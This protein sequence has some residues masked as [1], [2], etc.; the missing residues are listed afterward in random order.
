MT[1]DDAILA[2]YADGELDEAAC[3]AVDEAVLRDPELAH[4]LQ[5]H[6]ALKPRF[7]AAYDP[8]LDEPVHDSLTAMIMAGSPAP[9]AP[10]PRFGG[11]PAYAAMAACLVLG[12]ALGRAT[13]EAPLV[14]EHMVPKGRLV[15]ALDN[16]LASEPSGPIRIGVTFQSAS[17]L[18]RSFQ[19]PDTA[20]LACR[21][22]D[23][24]QVEAL[25]PF[26]SDGEFRTASSM[27]LAVAA[28][29]DARMTGEVFDAQ[30]ERYLRDRNW[31]P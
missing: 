10:P 12:L 4:R 8:V 21:S 29:I 26:S 15:A 18:C 1:I 13:L 20:G 23:R 2:A 6:L 7:S 25:T 3:R 5:A 16:G 27:P 14:G 9:P 17:G 22:G 30:S 28:A 31:A 11:W 24:W 19:T